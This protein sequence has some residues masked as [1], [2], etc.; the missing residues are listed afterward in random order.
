V[1]RFQCLEV[2]EA[3]AY[4]AAGGQALHLHRIIVDRDRAPRCFVRAVDRGEQ[5]AHLFDL[6][7]LR[8]VATAR[9][10]GV[11]VIKIDRPGSPRQHIDLC[12]GPLKKALAACDD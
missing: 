8:L 5:I 3:L 4:A 12:S 1:K 10:L 9:R 7:E 2:E 11:R 6:D